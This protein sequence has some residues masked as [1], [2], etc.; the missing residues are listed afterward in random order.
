MRDIMQTKV[1]DRFIQEISN[2]IDETALDDF[3][4]MRVLEDYTWS[5]LGIIDG[6]R[7]GVPPVFLSTA[8]FDADIISGELH[9]LILDHRIFKNPDRDKDVMPAIKRELARRKKEGWGHIHHSSS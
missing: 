5:L 1:R 7:P 8:A 9:H 2:L 6:V 4:L 3:K